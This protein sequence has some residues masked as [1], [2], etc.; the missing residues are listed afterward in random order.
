[1]T[2]SHIDLRDHAEV[3]KHPVKSSGGNEFLVRFLGRWKTEGRQF[4]SPAGGAAA[5]AAE[6][7]FEWLAGENFLVH[8]FHGRIGD[9]AIACI[10]I[11]GHDPE[12][13]TYQTHCFFS[14]GIAHRWRA[15]EH[16][17]AWKVTGEWHF[18]GKTMP[19]RCLTTFSEDGAT[20]S[21]TWEYSSDG[22]NWQPFWNVSSTKIH[23]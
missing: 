7:S 3:A 16:S 23:E 11:I 1:M 17:G 8:R 21:G 15:Y 14:N 22:S 10:E 12:T 4:E 2:K 9:A 18:A 20:R 5:I 13:Q 6:E 19:V